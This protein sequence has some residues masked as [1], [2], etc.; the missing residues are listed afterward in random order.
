MSTAAIGYTAVSDEVPEIEGPSFYYDWHLS[1]LSEY[2]Q[3]HPEFSM[4]VTLDVSGVVITGDLVGRNTWFDELASRYQGDAGPLTG[5]MARLGR[6]DSSHHE[7]EVFVHLR[8][9]HR[10]SSLGVRPKG[11]QGKGLMWRG[12]LEAIDGWSLGFRTDAGV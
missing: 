7:D 3:D 10:E 8:D 6:W 2:A 5:A 9:A 4:S 1:A 12:K 11:L